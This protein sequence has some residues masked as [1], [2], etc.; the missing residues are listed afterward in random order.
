[1]KLVKLILF[2]A[3]IFLS[4]R[5]ATAQTCEIKLGGNL[6]NGAPL[7]A[8]P[9]VITFP[10]LAA[11]ANFQYT[12]RISETSGKLMDLTFYIFFLERTGSETRIQFLTVA[13]GKD[14]IN[15]IAGAPASLH[16]M[17]LRYD[18][19]SLKESSSN[20]SHIQ[21]NTNTAGPSNLI[22]IELDFSLSASPNSITSA[23]TTRCPIKEVVKIINFADFDNDGKQ[24]TFIFR[25]ETGTWAI[26]NSSNGNTWA[27][28]WG[29]PGDFPFAADFTGDKKTDL[30]VWRP[31]NGHWYVCRSEDSYDCFKNPLVLQFGLPGDRPVLKDI[32]GDGTFDFTVFRLGSNI[33][34]TFYTFN[35]VANEITSENFG[36]IYDIPGGVG[37]NR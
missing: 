32:D 21:F 7:T 17:I 16:T 5:P 18:G 36:L 20:K 31:S 28:Q 34:G 35:R 25:P 22:E 27:R 1:M 11:N 15:G 19:S 13:D 4:I 6:N 23:I 33:Y 30:A 10:N 14:I 29:L 12:T 24:D 2:T 3:F 8:V 9:A 37:S 26:K